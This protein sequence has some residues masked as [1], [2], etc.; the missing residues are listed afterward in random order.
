MNFKVFTFLTNSAKRGGYRQQKN[1]K[2]QELIVIAIILDDVKNI[3]A[4]YMTRLW[5]NKCFSDR[6]H[7]ILFPSTSINL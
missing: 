1:V 4:T 2:R 6:H 3:I 5:N 7:V